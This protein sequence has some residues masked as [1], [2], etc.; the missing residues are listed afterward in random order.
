MENAEIIEANRLIAEFMGAKKAG[1]STMGKDDTM[2]ELYSVV[3]PG[4][5]TRFYDR[6]TCN[7]IWESTG[8]RYHKDWNWLMPVVEKIESLSN[9]NVSYEVLLGTWG[10]SITKHWNSLNG[11][12]YKDVSSVHTSPM[13]N[14]LD[15]TYHAVLDFLTWYNQQ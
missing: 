1:V 6:I 14:K 15:A 9:E 7:G 12:V 5:E 2:A 8:L 4:G 3:T 11:R 10:C 13:N